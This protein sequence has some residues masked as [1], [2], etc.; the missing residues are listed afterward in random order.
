MTRWRRIAAIT[1]LSILGL[2]VVFLIAAFV[3]VQTDWF[4]NYVRE[5]IIAIT[6][7]STG[8]KVEIQAFDFD[9]SHMRA[10]VKG[11]ILH[12]TE[13]PTEAPLF[14]AQTLTVDLKILPSFSKTVD[15]RALNVE[16]PIANVIVYPDG[17]LN[18][19]APKVKKP[20]DKSGLETIVELAVGRFD[21][22][23]GAFT[24]AEQKMPLDAHGENLR[25]QLSYNMLGRSYEG[26]IALDPLLLGF[27]KNSPVRIHADLPLV[28]E[29]DRITLKDAKITTAKSEILV[30][31]SVENMTSPKTSAHLNARL[32]VQE[33]AP[34]AG[35]QVAAQPST[36]NA[37]VA[38]TIDKDHTR[39]STAR[40]TLGKSQV[41]ASG[42]LQDKVEMNA[43]LAT[44]ELF[45]LFKVDQPDAGL[46]QVATAI[47]AS[48][49][50]S[51]V[52]L[53][54]LK[55]DAFGGEFGGTASLEG[56]QNL[57]LNG[58]LRSFD[59]R[60]LAK[61]FGG[62]ALPYDGIISGPVHVAMDLKKKG[63]TGI[64]ADTRLSITPGKR[65]IPVSGR[66]VADYNG[67]ADS[68]VVGDSYVALPNT[69]LDLS[70]AL[71]KQLRVKLVSRNLDDFKP[72]GDIPLKL[73]QGSAN[74]DG[75]VTGNLSAPKIVGHVAVTNFAVEGRAFDRFVADVN[76]ASAGASLS[77]AAITRGAM[78]MQLAANVG[79]RKWSPTPNQPLSATARINNADVADLLAL[80]GQTDIP[81]TGTL[82]A[83]AQVGGTIGSPRGN[84]T[85][86]SVNGKLYDQPYDR[87]QAQVN[88]QDQLV[89][90]SNT[91][92]SSGP[93]R[94]DLNATFQHPK[95]SFST[96]TVQAHV[97]SN[98]I[99]LGQFQQFAK[100]TPGLGGTANT[101]LD[102]A[103]NLKKVKDQ[104]EFQLT[105]VNGDL[106][107][108]G[109]RAN[110]E[111]Y[112]DLTAALRTANN[113]VNYKIDSDFAGSTLH[114]T[115]A[116]QLTPEYP[117]NASAQLQNLPIERVLALVGKSDIQ[118]RGNLS[119]NATYSGTIKNPTGSAELTL[120][121][122]VV[123]EE[124]IDRV[125]L[126]ATLGAQEV[127][128][129]QL[130]IQAGPSTIA[131]NAHYTHAPGDYTN[132]Q[133]R[134]QV[135]DS[136]IHLANLHAVQ[137]AEPGLAGTLRLAAEGA[138]NIVKS[139][140]Q[141]T[142]LN[143]NANT[144]GLVINKQQ[145]GEL[146]LVAHTSGDRLNFALDSDI[147]KSAIHGKGDM[148]LRGDYPVTGQL[149]F[150]NV[151]FGGL[152]PFFNSTSSPAPDFDALV[153][154][155]ATFSGPVKKPEEMKARLEIG[156]LEAGNTAKSV[157]LKNQGPMVIAVDHSIVTVQVA[158]IVGPQTDINISGTA[159]IQGTSQMN[160]TVN[161]SSNLNIL[162]QMTKSVYSAGVVSI[163]ANVRG[164]LSQPLL[165]G[166]MELKNASVNVIDVPNGLSN[167]N[168]VIVFNGNNA[169]IQ[170]LTAESGGGKVDIGGFVG[171]GGGTL[172]YALKAN[173][174]DVRVRY[175]EGASNRASANL[176]LTGTSDKSVLGG[177]VTIQQIGFSPRN[178]FGSMLSRTS[179]PTSAPSAP[180]G[181]LAGMRLDIR[182]RTAP[183]VSFQTSL[184]QNIQADAD[185]HLRGTAA[186][187]G[188]TGRV[189][190][191]EGTLVFFGTKYTVNQGTISFYNPF[192]ITPVLDIDLETV[193][194]GVDVVVTV[195]GPIDNMK[196]TYRSDP[197]LQFQE[198]VALLATGRT[199]TSDPTILANE[200]AAPAQSFQQMGESA[201]VG[202]AVANPLASRLQR[203]FGVNQ[204]K[205]DPTFT[206]GSELPQA[207]LTL[208]Q[209]VTNNVTFTYITN[210]TEANSQT[211]RIEWALSDQWSAIATREETGRFGVDFFYKK[212]FR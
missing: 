86:T 14:Q 123:Y 79:L 21:L 144:S 41:E 27:Q 137:K 85:L 116:T 181:P 184:A 209:Q 210:L 140:L 109:L 59:T 149:T 135:A 31:G 6:E 125:R 203:V 65:G 89:T 182:I 187:P 32:D 191:S 29:K 133:L 152:R 42:S 97:A 25:A 192:A 172:T 166:R 15:I 95:D 136:T 47:K 208:Q 71:N 193:A 1:G 207:R 70:G 180:S 112:G 151:T 55:L 10:T 66:L 62:K 178:D 72:L 170:T 40:L 68:V 155:Q 183:T 105:S 73:N 121:K 189:N 100:Q 200:P 36:L 77:N 110:N 199:P 87:L 13:K 104:T 211:I 146:K 20:S 54:P 130:E 60:T 33:F 99:N 102:V 167:A 92:L 160:V 145:L 17:S 57:A 127:D 175:P 69:R 126:R 93:S 185:L 106:A 84:F 22:N 161:A 212:K 103:G 159:P 153:E 194:K 169:T 128:V 2:L 52:E 90:L 76:A 67:A 190:I 64:V 162:Q 171:F 83:S 179:T 38:V 44:G 111:N 148:T 75:T 204:L 49:D 34:L 164:T 196:L 118:A 39:I 150:Q 141:V 143:A 12:G 107:V 96:G 4:R 195:S 147:A 158:H 56:Q 48:G 8:G 88:L 5:K 98:Q 61:L 176:N 37:D 129:P 78:Q 201:I 157:T 131:M 7:D 115:G 28:L 101:N 81:A 173:A 186:S 11:F 30:S 139:E 113:T 206:S 114:A 154:G 138:A 16:K 58:D 122:G 51:D 45:K 202:Q 117:T 50:F 9:W 120:A 18:V 19:P 53:N 142:N 134:F 63:S 174:K 124:P 188:M 94:L 163:Q 177:T 43:T 165:N 91:S 74:F 156:R 35:L 26:H 80:A 82:N 108:R 205:I 46:V 3:I 23:N 168:G 132:G 197:P 24:F 119:G 198:L